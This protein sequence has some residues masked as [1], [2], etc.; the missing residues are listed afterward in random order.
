MLFKHISLK[1]K[2]VFMLLSISLC[3][4]LI[5]GYQ[6]LH[7][8]KKALT[9]RIYQQLT[10]VRESKRAHIKS[11]FNELNGQVKSLAVDHTI[12]RAMRDFKSAYSRLDQT[13]LG[14]DQ[15][16]ELKSY[17]QETFIP[18]LQKNIEGNPLLEHYFPTSAA[19]QYLQYHYIAH[20]ANKTAE[21]HLLI[22]ADDKSYYS[23]IHAYNHPVLSEYLKN[24]SYYDLFL[25]D[26]DTGDIVY[27]VSKEVDFS[28]NLLTDA[29]QS[30]NL[31][32]LFK[33]IRNSPDYGVISGVDFDFYRPSYGQPA[34][35]MGTTIFDEDKKPIGVLVI[36]VSNS[37]VS[38]VMTG[39]KG[40][41]DQGLGDTGESYIVGADHLMRSD[42]RLLSTKDQSCY[43]MKTI[44][45]LHVG[46]TSA[47]KICD[48]KTSV[49][50]QRIESPVLTK[51]LNG[52]KG[53]EE[54]KS[55]SGKKTLAAYSP[56]QLGDLKFAIISQMDLDEA[57]AP[58]YAFQKELVISTVIQASIITVIA[59]LLAHFFTKP[60]ATLM[61][62][63]HKLSAGDTDIDIQMD[64]NDEFGELAKVLNSTGKLIKQQQ[65][66][67]KRK[68]HENKTLLL[69]IL[70]AKV[71]KQL[72]LGETKI[73]EKVS[74]V[75]VV[76]TTL[77]GFSE[78]LDSMDPEKA[79]TLLNDLIELFDRA[80]EKFDVEK[81]KTIGDS[82]LAASGLNIS[83][84]DHASRCVKFGLALLHIV[85]DI[86]K[87]FGTVL[88]LRVGIHSGNVL[89]GVVGKRNFAYDL[90]GE[91]VN[92]A[93]RIRFEAPLNSLIITNDAYERLGDKALFDQ[94][95]TI[96]T[97]AMGELDVWIYSMPSKNTIANNAEHTATNQT[98]STAT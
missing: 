44:E 98:L 13:T 93:G 82:Y 53:T 34:F 78:N 91:T 50:L 96:S 47:K 24:Y 16:D 70:P 65:Q 14:N 89:A 27:S 15:L 67:I 95:R 35:F 46:G 60:F 23:G 49:L 51:A 37:V 28:T 2:L 83:R 64:R 73:S 42:A 72:E 22:D 33:K 81:V 7:N 55:Y 68:E 61:E 12:I 40:W 48:L 87:D 58:I 56:L 97:Q 31:G 88:S 17:Y 4:I 80:A 3:S 77:R 25:I 36:Q 39:N 11:W 26:I 90:W 94:R 84:L 66:Q 38:N 21:K 45:G 54:I 41:K 62:G 59:M 29:Y 75:S 76:Y 8:G 71:A 63:V 20:N 5:V 52:L 6:G 10:S 92:I 69:N 85:E 18:R 30:S 32:R 79:I 1:S 19:T 43:A 86:N 57:N 9:A 74:N